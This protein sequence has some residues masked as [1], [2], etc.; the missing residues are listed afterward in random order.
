MMMPAYVP[1]IHTEAQTQ[2]TVLTELNP[3]PIVI[4][5]FLLYNIFNTL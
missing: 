2:G 1:Q 5:S 3:Q 4:T